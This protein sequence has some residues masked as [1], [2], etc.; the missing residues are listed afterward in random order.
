LDERSRTNLPKSPV[1]QAIAYARNQWEDLQTY[2]RDGELSVD[3]SVS[4]R[5]VRAQAIERKKLLICW[6]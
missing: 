1:S 3:N 2:T 6:K 5:N 4:E